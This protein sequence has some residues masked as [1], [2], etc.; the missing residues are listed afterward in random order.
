M[1]IE[2]LFYKK[3]SLK[4]TSLKLPVLHSISEEEQLP[5]DSDASVKNIS[6]NNNN[7]IAPMNPQRCDLPL[8]SPKSPKGKLGS[9]QQGTLVH[10]DFSP[11]FSSWF[12]HNDDLDTANFINSTLEEEA[13][14][15][16]I[17]DDIAFR[18]IYVA[19]LNDSMKRVA[20][21]SASEDQIFVL[22]I[23]FGIR[24]Y[25]QKNEVRIAPEFIREVPALAKQLFL[26]VTITDKELALEYLQEV[27]LNKATAYAKI[28]SSKTELILAVQVVGDLTRYLVS[29]KC[30]AYKNPDY[31]IIAESILDELFSSLSSNSNT[32]CQEYEKSMYFTA[33][34]LDSRLNSLTFSVE[35]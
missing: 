18:E 6:Y 10:F 32:V 29:K 31:P 30:A 4:C 14:S 15:Y 7:T 17:T 3:K 27:A 23:D 33:T 12:V 19:P 35:N 11:S 26:P 25:I 8:D 1:V 34:D 24:G 28:C 5:D 21:L 2:D 20:V 9:I 16:P 13:S 22:Y